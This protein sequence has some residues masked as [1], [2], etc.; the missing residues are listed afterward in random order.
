MRN[1]SWRRAQRDRSIARAERR[2]TALNWHGHEDDRTAWIR[3]AA[4]TPHPCS[5]YCCGNP[6]KWFGSVTRQEQ[7][8][9]LNYKDQQGVE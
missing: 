7:V 9:D 3:K 5:S 1:R 4:V 2:A 6:R 8:A